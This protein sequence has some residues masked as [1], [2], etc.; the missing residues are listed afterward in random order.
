MSSKPSTVKKEFEKG[1]FYMLL[2]SVMLSFFTLFAK[3]GTD[4]T[5]YF[6]LILLRFG[7]PFLLLT[8][9]FL[10]TSSFKEL[11]QN[12]NIKMQVLRAGCILLY[13]YSIFYY[14][15]YANLLDATVMQNTAPLLMPVLERLFFKHR[16]EK[17]VL[18]SIG[19]C[20]AGVLCILQP[21]SSIFAN[22][23]I[24]GFL[25]LLGQ[26]GSQVLYGHQAK[27]ENQKSN[28]FYQ[29]FIC[30]VVSAIAFLFSNEFLRGENSLE[31][32]TPLL[33]I[34]IVC[35]GVASILNQSL[36]GVAYMH[37]KASALAPFLYVSIIISALL[38]WAI[39]HHLPNWL[40]L[41]GAILVICGGLVQIYKRKKSV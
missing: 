7:I 31:H 24:A 18:I 20:F 6:L 27:Q 4:S 39:F 3:F 11:F 22:L 40:S 21:N 19:I 5:S 35:L 1:A 25:A 9:F 38:D 41:V 26:A 23:S 28:L 34:N 15:K 17:R 30:S 10:W 2:S 14:L 36:R 8:T 33:W 32:Y 16:F 37:G 29:F 13:Q 12:S